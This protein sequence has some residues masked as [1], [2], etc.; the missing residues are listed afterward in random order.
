VISNGIHRL[1]ATITS[2][3]TLSFQTQL[4]SI[5]PPTFAGGFKALCASTLPPS[6]A[7]A[8][9]VYIEPPIWVALETLGLIDRY[10]SLIASVGYEYIEANVLSTCAGKW[11]EPML[12][13]IRDWLTNTIVPWMV[14]PYARGATTS[15]FPGIRS[16]VPF[17]SQF[18]VSSGRS[19]Q[20]A[21]RCR[22]TLRLSYEQNPLRPAVSLTPDHIIIPDSDLLL[23]RTRE[24]FDIIIDFPESIGALHDLRVSSSAF[25][26]RVGYERT[27]I[28]IAYNASINVQI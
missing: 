23:C 26:Q 20:H 9:N 2:A 19:P 4:L 18:A 12:S 5:L 15:Q 11:S 16:F 8:T 27:L 14:W 1:G 21:A 3:Y 10:D 24:I 28:R 13:Q 7:H 17:L 25:A 6:Q 22:C